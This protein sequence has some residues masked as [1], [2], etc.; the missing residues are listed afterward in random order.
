MSSK[1]RFSRRE[2]LSRTSN[3]L[4]AGSVF[5]LLPRLAEAAVKP[6]TV[7]FIYVG[8]RQDFGWNQAHWVAAKKVAQIGGVKV[9]EQENVP[10]TVEVQKIMKSMIQIDGAKVIFATSF[11]YWPHV[12][13][14]AKE[15]P[16][17]L[18]T[19]IGRNGGQVT[20]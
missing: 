9:V 1:R 2:F 16:D 4:A 18:F 13:K 6:M 8:P 11:G 14:V 10:E 7:G 20:G 5:A 12:L 15:H 19:H 3:V 17:V